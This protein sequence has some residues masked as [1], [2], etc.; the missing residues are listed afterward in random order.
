M[1]KIAFQDFLKTLVKL[2][3]SFKKIFLTKSDNQSQKNLL[4]S[5][6]LDTLLKKIIY[7]KT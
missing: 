5:C 3:K 2:N 1:N 6:K 7:A 4:F